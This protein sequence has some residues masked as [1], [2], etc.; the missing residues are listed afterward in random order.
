MGQSCPACVGWVA[1]GV[2]AELGELYVD[3]AYGSAG[4]EAV[5]SDD[6]GSFGDGRDERD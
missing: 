1:C 2:E 6:E 3:V 4:D 5:D